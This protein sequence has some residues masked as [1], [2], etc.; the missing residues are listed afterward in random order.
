M[1]K[2]KSISVREAA[3]RLGCTIKYVRACFM[4]SGYRGQH[5]EIEGGR[6]RL[7][8]SKSTCSNGRPAMDDLLTIPEAA[9][10]L[11]LKPSTLRDW[12]SPRKRKLPYYKIGGL[13]RIRRSD[14]EAVIAA[15]L[16]PVGEGAHR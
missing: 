12:I 7:Q 9:G 16:V 6:F 13:V 11:R 4:R 1:A 10:L 8:P 2:P 14:V 3:K 15:S 5:Y